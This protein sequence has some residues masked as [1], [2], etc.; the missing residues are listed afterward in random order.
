MRFTDL[1]VK[2]EAREQGSALIRSQRVEDTTKHHLRQHQL[3]TSR[4][5]ACHSALH[6]DHIIGCREA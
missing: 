6:L 3:V 4:D 5:F 2:D 1:L